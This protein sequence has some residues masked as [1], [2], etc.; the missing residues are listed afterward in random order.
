[1]I[2]VYYSCLPLTRPPHPSTAMKKCLYKRGEVLS[3]EEGQF[4]MKKITAEIE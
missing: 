3:L 4:R 2:D 1:V